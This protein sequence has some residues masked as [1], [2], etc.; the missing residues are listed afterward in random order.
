MQK[1]VNPYDVLLKPGVD[2]GCCVFLTEISP[3]TWCDG[4]SGGNFQRDGRA[5]AG[6]VL[7]IYW[8]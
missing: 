5:G 3:D 8:L 7:P 2:R 4:C 1:G 6:K